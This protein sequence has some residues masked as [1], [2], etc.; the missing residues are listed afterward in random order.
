MDW[1]EEVLSK[2][3]SHIRNSSLCRGLL[4]TMSLGLIVAIVVNYMLQSVCKGW[5]DVI[6]ERYELV[7]ALES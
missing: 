6:I 4:Y 2:V 5:I 3:K 1:I 7:G